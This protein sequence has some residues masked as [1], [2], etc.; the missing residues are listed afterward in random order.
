MILLCNNQ[1]GIKLLKASLLYY[2]EKISDL[3]LTTGTQNKCAD[4]RFATL[5]LINYRFLCCGLA[6]LSNVRIC[7]SRMSS[8]ICN[9]WTL[10][11][12]LHAWLLFTYSA[13]IYLRARIL[14]LYLSRFQF[15]GA[16][17]QD[18]PAV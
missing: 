8:R 2:S 10:Q 7:D 15:I 14:G 13:Y 1:K 3:Q 5:P 12:S 17:K 9:L 18:K 6:Y 16:F 4:L 11:K